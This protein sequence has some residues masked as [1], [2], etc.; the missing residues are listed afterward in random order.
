[1]LSESKVVVIANSY[2]ARNLAQTA[3]LPLDPVA[4]QISRLTATPQSGRLKS[5]VVAEKYICPATDGM[6]SLGASYAPQPV[7]LTSSAVADQENLR[8]VNAALAQLPL[9][10]ICGARVSVRCSASDYFPIAGAVPDLDECIRVFGPLSRD[11]SARI[12]AEPTCLP[13]L[14][15]N[16]AHGS[17]GLTSCPLTAELIASQ[18]NGESPPLPAALVESLSPARFILRDLKRQRDPDRLNRDQR[19]P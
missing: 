6:H 5:V 12:D 1:V 7:N 17:Y 3:T 4:G 8:G 19:T 14:F 10:G 18:A 9:S 13:G 11:A 16:V 2:Q 15:V